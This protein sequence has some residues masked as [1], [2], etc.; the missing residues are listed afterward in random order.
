MGWNGSELAADL[1]KAIGFLIPAGR[2]RTVA[3]RKIVELFEACDCDTMME[4]ERLCWDAGLRYDPVKDECVYTPLPEGKITP[5]GRF[6]SDYS[7]DIQPVNS[8]INMLEGRP[9]TLNLHLNP[10]RGCNR[11]GAACDK[12]KGKP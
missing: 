3:A 8:P 10:C 7:E 6:Q 1:W 11:T 4:A 12:C 9:L 2:D 5:P